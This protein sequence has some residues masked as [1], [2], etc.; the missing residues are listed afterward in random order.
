MKSTSNTLFRLQTFYEISLL[1]NLAIALTCSKFAK[2][3]RFNHVFVTL[4][5]K[6]I[7]PVKSK[8]IKDKVILLSNI[9]INLYSNE[10]QIYFV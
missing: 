9:L 10:T 1:Y 6:R 2:D 8:H 3:F 5:L 4:L 7:S